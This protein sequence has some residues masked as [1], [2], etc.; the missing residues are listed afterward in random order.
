MQTIKL[1]LADGFFNRLQSLSGRGPKNNSTRDRAVQ[2][3]KDWLSR[4]SGI[5]VLPQ[6]TAQGADVSY[7]QNKIEIHAEVK[8]TED[9]NIAWSKIKVSGEPSYL[10]ICAGWPVFRVCNVFS[11][12]PF[13]HILKKM[14]ILHYYPSLVG[15]F[16]ELRT[17]R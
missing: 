3:V 2:I 11:Q 14:K 15:K 10:G 16:V 13:I 8:G 7:L 6:P 9:S 4:Q 1:Q 12:S 5:Q 17:N